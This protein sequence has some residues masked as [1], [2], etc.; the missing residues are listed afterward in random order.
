MQVKHII[1]HVGL[2]KTATTTLQWWCH[3]NR[4][5]LHQSNIEYPESYDWLG[6][7]RQQFLTHM[8]LNNE[9]TDLENIISKCDRETL[10]LSNEGLTTHLYDFNLLSFENFR[11]LT[12]DIKKS[13]FMVT[14]DKQSWLKSFYKQCVLSPPIN[15]YY[16]T[17]LEYPEFCLLKRIK[18]LIDFEH[19]KEKVA[20]YYGA[21]K[22]K[23]IRY[24]ENWFTS[25]G[26][27]LELNEIYNKPQLTKENISVS[28]DL[29]ELIRQV[30]K[31]NLSSNVRENVL[32][33]FQH[34]FNTKHDLLKIYKVKETSCLEVFYNLYPK[35][36]I[37][38]QKINKLIGCM[39]G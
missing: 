26:E 28:D 13:V 37:Q 8:F 2:P 34:V 15:E 1:L 30:N 12:K 22:L 31:M 21:N 35:N 25:F 16:G 9:F 24:E 11:N 4:K 5:F 20:E 39:V 27:I 3:N 17:S 36:Q 33:H 6:Q 32:G 23:V 14:R 29:V 18:E 38:A 10:L 19:L 7:P